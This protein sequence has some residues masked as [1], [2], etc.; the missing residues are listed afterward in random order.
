MFDKSGDPG[1][2]FTEF[3]QQ[4]LTSLLSFIFGIFLARSLGDCIGPR[5][6]LWL[7][8]GTFIQALFTMAAAI[9]IWKD[10]E[11]SFAAGG[12]TWTKAEG[13]AALSFASISMGVQGQMSKRV[14]THFGTAG[15]H[16]KT[17]DKT[18]IKTD[19][20][21]FLVVLT[22][23]WVELIG[24]PKL[25]FRKWVKARDFRMLA[26][27]SFLLGGFTGRAVIGKL[28]DAKTFGIGTGLRVIIAVCWFF[29]PSKY[30]ARKNPSQEKV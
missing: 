11:T 2:N 17:C 15:M 4:A 23:L 10:N 22:S 20:N 29:I 16:I 27:F 12:P 1:P 5:T 25:F 6:R 3:D 24:E 18:F 21:T 8:M 14:D 26:V 9:F 19:S 13:F 30:P 28:G 7:F